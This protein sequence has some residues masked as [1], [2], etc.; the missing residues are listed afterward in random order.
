MSEHLQQGTCMHSHVWLFATLWTIAHQASLSMGIF[1]AKIMEWVA[2][3]SSRGSS[4]PRDWIHVSCI[5]GRFFTAEPL[6][7]PLQPGSIP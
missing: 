7:K 3:S 6:R 4:P 5:A 2:I 1:Q